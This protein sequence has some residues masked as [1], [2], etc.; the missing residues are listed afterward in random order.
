MKRRKLYINDSLIAAT[1]PSYFAQKKDLGLLYSRH[2]LAPKFALLAFCELSRPMYCA[3]VTIFYVLHAVICC[4]ARDSEIIRL[5][6][7]VHGLRIHHTF[8][9]FY[10]YSLFKTYFDLNIFLCHVDTMAL[11][12]SVNIMLL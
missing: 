2:S 8:F 10:Q 11:L 9:Y 6:D 4:T 5:I 12:I 7:A 1:P 3:P